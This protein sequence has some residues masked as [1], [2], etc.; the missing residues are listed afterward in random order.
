MKSYKQLF[1][2][3]HQNEIEQNEIEQNETKY[4]SVKQKIKSIVL[5]VLIFLGWMIFFMGIGFLLRFQVA[6]IHDLKLLKIDWFAL[7]LISL[8]SFTLTLTIINPIKDKR[9][10]KKK[11]EEKEKRKLL[12][13]KAK[14]FATSVLLIDICTV[15]TKFGNLESEFTNKF[16]LIMEQYRWIRNEQFDIKGFQLDYTKETERLLLHKDEYRWYLT[17]WAHIEGESSFK[18]KFARIDE[19]NEVKKFSFLL[20]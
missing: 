13:D 17:G 3:A 10:S 16:K 7:L 14:E 18:F 1:N 2:E 12:E 4:N 11:E 20:S 19:T 8:I 15:L 9:D 5:S 6:G